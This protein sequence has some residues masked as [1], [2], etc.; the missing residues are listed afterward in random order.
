MKTF[1]NPVYLKAIHDAK[2]NGKALHV[3][4]LLS[5]GGVHSHLTHIFAMLD[6]AKHE[7]LE[8]VFVHCFLDGRDVPPTS[9]AGFVRALQEKCEELGNT[10]IVTSA[11]TVLKPDMTPLSAVS[12]CRTRMQSMRWKQATLKMSRMNSSSRLYP[13][14]KV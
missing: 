7:G 14:Q 3:L 6:M 13:A 5:D 11:G 1:E 12:V 10:R 9:G 4:G 2:E 8:K